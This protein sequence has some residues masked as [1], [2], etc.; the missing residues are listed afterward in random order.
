MPRATS[1]LRWRAGRRRTRPGLQDVNLSVRA[2]ETVGLFGIRGS[3]AD[4]IAEG[5]AGRARGMTGRIILGAKSFRVFRNPREAKQAGIAYVPPERKR[6]GL[7]LGFPIRQ[8]LTMLI[9]RALARWVSSGAARKRRSP[10]AHR[11]IRHPLPGLAATGRPTQRRQPAKGA[12]W[13][14]GSSMSQR[15]SFSMS[16]RAASTSE[17][18][19][20]FIAFCAMWPGGGRQCWSLRRISKRQ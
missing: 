12:A 16:R 3:G 17:R 10:A 5:L 9:F 19:S 7:V 20:R 18:G 14:A 13:P 1:H 8:N 4:V 6:D 15:W 2:G 11:P